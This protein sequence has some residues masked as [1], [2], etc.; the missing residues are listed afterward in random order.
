MEKVYLVLNTDSLIYHPEQGHK[1]HNH[2]A[3]KHQEKLEREIGSV[4]VCARV[5]VCMQCY[6]LPFMMQWLFSFH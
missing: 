5:C 2:P 3:A 1:N 4:R 6:T